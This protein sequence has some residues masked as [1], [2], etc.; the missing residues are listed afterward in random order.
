LAADPRL[1]RGTILWNLRL[2]GEART[3]FEDLRQSYLSD[4]VNN[5][6]L[7]NYLAELGLYRSAIFAARQVLNLAGL[8][9]AGTMVAPRYFNF[10]RFGT[11]FN[12]LVSPAAQAHGFH[13]LFIYS[14]MRQESLFEGFIRSSAGARGLMQ[15]IP[16]TG[17]AIHGLIGWPQDYTAEDLYRPK[18]SVTFG[19][20]HLGD[21]REIFDGNLYATLAGYNAGQGNASIWLDEAG[22]DLDLYVEIVRFD[23]TRR[24]IRGIYEIYSIYHRLYDRSF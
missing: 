12:E 8:D 17:Q 21:L 14:V 9:D 2:F 11:Y 16:T 10:L 18:V 5:Y 4:P 7:A 23:E 13:P 15:I 20:D 24:Y 1:Q 22:D 19:T 3:E 6:R